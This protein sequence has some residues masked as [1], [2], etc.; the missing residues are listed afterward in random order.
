MYNT[1]N[2]LK[3]ELA[4]EGDK[5]VSHR[6]LMIASLIKDDSIIYNL[7]ACKD[8]LTTMKCLQQCGI[9]IK[10]HFMKFGFKIKG[11]TL[12]QPQS[13]LNCE[14]SGSTARML[15]GLLAGQGISASFSGDDSLTKRPMRRIINPLLR[16]GIKIKSH[17]NHLPI[18]INSNISRPLNYSEKTKS[19]QVKSSLMFAALGSTQ[20]SHI[21]YN[22]NTRDHTERALTHINCHL[23]I[24]ERIAIKKTSFKKGFK[25]QIPGDISNAAFI[26]AGAILIKDSDVIIKNVLYNKT[27]N[28]FI[29]LLIQIGAEIKIANIKNTLGGEKACDLH[30]RYSGKL[31]AKNIKIDNIISLIDEIPILSVLAT[32][33][34]G[35]ITI[36]NAEE[37]KFKETDR[38][39]AIYQNLLQMGAQITLTKNGFR[40]VG[41]KRLYNTSI[42]HYD[43]HRI[44]MSFDILN[45]YRNK[46]FANYSKNLA[47]ISFP[48]FQQSLK[49]LLT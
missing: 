27:R 24:N 25:I 42:N 47:K 1:N 39:T 10:H 22:Q 33:F 30:V 34:N 20:Y 6:A 41:G 40:I 35:S 18:A 8:V 13:I 48:E 3:G 7:S 16:M 19:A 38:I 14:N 44:A 17:N 32:Q 4:L 28:G 31:N 45:L 26:I 21:A 12:S 49:G 2:I 11:G 9:S 15:I 43:D 46:K 37:L 36:S 29:E 23:K 5:S